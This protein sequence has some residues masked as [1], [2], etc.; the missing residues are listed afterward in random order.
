MRETTNDN[1]VSYVNKDDHWRR[2]QSP[3]ISN[4]RKE[5]NFPKSIENS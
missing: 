5:K 3:S 4:T 1:S 2:D